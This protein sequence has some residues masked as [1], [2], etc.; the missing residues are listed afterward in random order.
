MTTATRRRK[1]TA[2]KT[3]KRTKRRRA[4]DYS[5]AVK[6]INRER[7]LA[8]VVRKRGN[9]FTLASAE[10]HCVQFILSKNPKH[11]VHTIES[12]KLIHSAFGK[13]GLIPADDNHYG[14]FSDFIRSDKFEGTAYRLLNLDLMGYVCGTLYVDLEHINGLHNAEHIT[15]TQCKTTDKIRNVHTDGFRQWAENKFSGD[16]TLETLKSAL[17]NY[18]CAD[19]WEYKREAGKVIVMRMFMFKR[20]AGL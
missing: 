20:K 17:S 18:D 1:A 5:G 4:L 8:R 14:Q 19:H 9:Y 2:T 6:T 16:V 15:L 3:R 7:G 11:T 10:G 12:E 13:T